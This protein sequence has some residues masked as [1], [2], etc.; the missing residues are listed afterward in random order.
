VVFRTFFGWGGFSGIGK[1][2][3]RDACLFGIGFVVIGIFS[4]ILAKKA[5]S[6]ENSNISP[7]LAVEGKGIKRG[8]TAVEAGVLLEDRLTRF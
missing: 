3:Q 8:L 5:S 1:Y 2:H 4:T 6:N 7:K